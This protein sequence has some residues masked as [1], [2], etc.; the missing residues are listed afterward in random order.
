MGK[1]SVTSL[2]GLGDPVLD[3]KG[4]LSLISA[5]IFLS[6]KMA[7]AT[8]IA[9]ELKGLYILVCPGQPVSA[10]ALV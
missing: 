3:V 4:F 2:A 7:V 9:S 10:C 6:V 1:C 8:V 5:S